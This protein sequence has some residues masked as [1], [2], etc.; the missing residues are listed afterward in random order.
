MA[1]AKNAADWNRTAHQ[2]ASQIN[3]NPFRKGSPVK[4]SE[5]NPT[6]ERKTVYIGEEGL[7]RMLDRQRRADGTVKET[8]SRKPK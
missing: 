3:S 2:I 8:E 6:I 1:K 5:V 4:P 7:Q